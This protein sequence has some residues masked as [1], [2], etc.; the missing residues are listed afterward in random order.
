MNLTSH[1]IED[2]RS[3]TEHPGWLTLKAHWNDIRK[4]LQER[5]EIVEPE[6]YRQVQ[7]KCQVLKGILCGGVG[8]PEELIQQIL[9]E[10]ERKENKR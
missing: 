6:E 4:Q 1:D 7:G 3:L 10:I 2:L 9:R 5:L 8:S